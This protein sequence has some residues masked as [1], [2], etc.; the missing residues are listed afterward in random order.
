MKL[1]STSAFKSSNA[2]ECTIYLRTRL[3]EL[4]Q[5]NKM[6]IIIILVLL[7]LIIN[8]L[9]ITLIKM[10]FVSLLNHAMPSNV[11]YIYERDLVKL[12]QQIDYYYIITAKI[13]NK[14]ASYNNS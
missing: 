2:I 4:S 12:S 3:I 5:V 11:Q 8:V 10:K 9:H 1:H 6:I 14:C 13:N 7:K